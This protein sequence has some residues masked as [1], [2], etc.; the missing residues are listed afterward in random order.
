MADLRAGGIER[1]GP[2]P[3][4]S[5]A[6]R[7]SCWGPEAT[8]TFPHLDEAEENDQGQGQELGGREGVLHAGGGLHAVAVHSREQHCGDR[9]A[10]SVLPDRRSAQAQGEPSPFGG[11]DPPGLVS[12]NWTV[13]RPKVKAENHMFL[14]L[15]R[16]Q[17]KSATCRST[18]SASLHP[19]NVWA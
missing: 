13:L 15:K 4:H 10:K 17:S 19:L 8:L 14:T 3:R 6:S 16:G 9:A 5:K 18:A 11:S 12:V 1:W 2:L 7:D